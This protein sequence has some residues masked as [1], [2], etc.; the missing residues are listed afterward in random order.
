MTNAIEALL[1]RLR[2]GWSPKAD[3]IDP[4][5][6]QRDLIDWRFYGERLEGVY[7]VDERWTYSNTVTPERE[8]QHGGSRWSYV[9]RSE[10]LW[11]D[12]WLG[13]ALTTAR[14]YWLYDAEEG[15]K[16]AYLGG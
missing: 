16:R 2:S 15:A 6:P 7:A 1:E 3:E 12:P 11:I 9:T 8:L 10:V 14:F 4:A 13:W 5:V